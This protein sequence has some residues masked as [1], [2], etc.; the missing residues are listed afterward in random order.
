MLDKSTSGCDE[1]GGYSDGVRSSDWGSIKGQLFVYEYK[2]SRLTLPHSE[3]MASNTFSNSSW[4]K[5]RAEVLRGI[6]AGVKS[7]KFE[8][9]SRMFS[10]HIV[11]AC[12]KLWSDRPSVLEL[13]SGEVSFY[14][15]FN[16][17]NDIPA[18]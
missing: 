8:S 1:K 4:F 16:L 6:R 15:S 18:T 12:A 17:S 5:N 14:D 3:A 11:R 7:G 10:M 2:V 9:S 13:R